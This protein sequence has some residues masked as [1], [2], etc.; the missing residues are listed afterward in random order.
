MIEE[1]WDFFRL[2]K[3]DAG[4]L[5]SFWLT[6]ILLYLNAGL[7][8]VDLYHLVKR[9]SKAETVSLMAIPGAFAILFVAVTAFS[10]HVLN[11]L[12]ATY[13]SEI[14]SLLVT[15]MQRDTNLALLFVVFLY[16][17]LWGIGLWRQR[18]YEHGSRKR[19]VLS[20]IP[21]YF[22]W[23]I[24]V[25]G[26][27][28][29][30]LFGESILHSF[31]KN[32]RDGDLLALYGSHGIWLYLWM[33]GI[34]ILAC[35]E[36]VLLVGF[37]SELLLMR[38]PLRYRSGK[39]AV[40]FVGFYYLFCQNAVFRGTFLAETALVLPLC[41]VILREAASPSGVDS[42]SMAYMAFFLLTSAVF[43][44]LIVIRPVMRTL[45]C[46]DTWGQRRQIS[47]LFCTEYFLL[48]PVFR[49]RS[50]TVTYHFIIDEQDAAGVYYLPLL[51]NVSGW[52]YSENKK[53]KW[54]MLTLADGRML[55][56]S[57]H[58]AEAAREM[59]SYASNRLYARKETGIG[60]N[61]SN[62]NSMQGTEEAWNPVGNPAT[63]TYQ[64]LVKVFLGLM[65]LLFMMGYQ[66]LK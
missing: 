6:M 9:K 63:T 4:Y 3:A 35:K 7:Y 24:L 26:I 53:E 11:L 40:T 21:D 17:V 2:Y 14:L 33:Y 16:Q 47:E 34:Y 32:A 5:P 28:Y 43:V 13:R 57:E 42:F 54:R 36:A 65:I 52:I 41:V 59:L 51:T 37:L 46:F 62:I 10:T 64:K 58:E 45:A 1:L 8:L 31:L 25:C 44:V 23:I 30:L 66:V 49:N 12:R 20:C 56:V 22:A 19:W 39:N 55:E 61:L 18:R 48:Q 60:G 15:T 27:G 29:H 50:F 38:I